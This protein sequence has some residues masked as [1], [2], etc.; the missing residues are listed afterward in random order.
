MYTVRPRSPEY[1]RFVTHLADEALRGKA[2]WSSNRVASGSVRR[3][4]DLCSR[5]RNDLGLLLNDMVV[6]GGLGDGRRRRQSGNRSFLGGHGWARGGCGSTDRALRQAVLALQDARKDVVG[7]FDSSHREGPNEDINVTQVVSAGIL[8]HKHGGELLK[9]IARARRGA[10]A[11]HRRGDGAGPGV[12][13]ADEFA[14]AGGELVQEI[15]SGGLAWLHGRRKLLEVLLL[16]LRNR[17]GHHVHGSGARTCDGFVSV[18]LFWA[19]GAEEGKVEG[20]LGEAEILRI[21]WAR[22]VTEAWRT[23][24]RKVVGDGGCKL[25]LKEISVRV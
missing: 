7:D 12:Q 5:R 21:V 25:V 22:K 20:E 18:D 15:G 24:S 4:A 11:K 3:R 19:G 9:V 6:D 23:A 13:A 1:L 10:L 14:V 8:A 17:A 2:L 16:L